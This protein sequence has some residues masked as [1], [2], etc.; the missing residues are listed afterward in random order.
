M[1]DL[2]L[3]LQ[4]DGKQV[5]QVEKGKFDDSHAAYFCGTVEKHQVPPK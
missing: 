4:L 2:P 1:S 5:W 3:S